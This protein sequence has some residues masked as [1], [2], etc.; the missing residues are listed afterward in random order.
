MRCMS[1]YVLM[2]SKATRKKS[3]KA[4]IPHSAGDARIWCH[5]IK[6]RLYHWCFKATEMFGRL[7]ETVN[8]SNWYNH[9]IGLDTSFHSM[10]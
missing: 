4:I 7:I 6:V 3:T 5:F 2:V 1:Y 9:I 10:I 8:S